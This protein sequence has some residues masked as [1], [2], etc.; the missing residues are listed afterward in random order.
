MNGGDARIAVVPGAERH[1]KLPHGHLQRGILIIE[2]VATIGCGQNRDEGDQ[3][4]RQTQIGLA[5]GPVNVKGNDDVL[6]TLGGA[7][8]ETVQDCPIKG[9]V[10]RH[11][12]GE[13]LYVVSKWS[14]IG[15]IDRK[16]NKE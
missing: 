9:I 10:P 15:T 2:R 3:V 11:D 8:Q 13:L 14:N 12:F 4:R 7:N 6:F 1:N 5:I 16:V